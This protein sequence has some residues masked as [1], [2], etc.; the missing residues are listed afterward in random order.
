MDQETKDLLESGKLINKSVKYWEKQINNWFKKINKKNLSLEE[1]RKLESE[2]L[3]L[4]A[5][6]NM[7]VKNIDDWSK[8]AKKYAKK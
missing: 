7:E 3:L 8:K 6:A 4:E 2:F 5:R 1:A